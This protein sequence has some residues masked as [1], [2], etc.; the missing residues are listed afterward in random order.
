VAL[1]LGTTTSGS[2][3]LV[4]EATAGASAGVNDVDGGTTTIQSPAIT[5]PSTGTLTLT[6]NWYL[7]HLNNATSADFFRV[8]VVGSTNT[9]VFQQLGAASDR[10]GAWS[11]LSANLSSF[12]GQSV[13]IVVEAADAGT[14][15]LVE[16]GLDDLRITQQT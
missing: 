11:S 9:V 16:A 4:T 2:N 3:D 14:A 5:L 6:A 1:Q 12:A 8:R 7:A 10:A 15:S 13:R